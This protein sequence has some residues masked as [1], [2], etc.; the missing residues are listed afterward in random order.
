MTHDPC[1]FCPIRLNCD[2]LS[3][4]CRLSPGEVARFRPDLIRRMNKHQRYEIKRR[5]MRTDVHRAAD[6]KRA[7]QYRSRL[8]QAIGI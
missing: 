5:A 2:Y 8:R 3:G 1:Q 4:M 6:A 7:R